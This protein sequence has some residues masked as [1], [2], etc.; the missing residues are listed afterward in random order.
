MS[1]S[2]LGWSCDTLKDGYNAVLT[3]EEASLLE[4]EKEIL[5][6][7]E[8]IGLIPEIP[9]QTVS[10]RKTLYLPCVFPGWI[11]RPTFRR[12]WKNVQLPTPVLTRLPPAEESDSWPPSC[13]PW[14]CCLAQANSETQP[15]ILETHTLALT[16]VTKL[17][18]A[19]SWLLAYIHV[20]WINQHGKLQSQSWFMLSKDSQ[21][22]EPEPVHAD[23]A[24]P[25]DGA[26]DQDEDREAHRLGCM[27][28]PSKSHSQVLKMYNLVGRRCCMIQSHLPQLPPLGL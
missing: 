24:E 25:E 16:V 10:K 19:F 7:I 11:L 28:T 8:D 4:Q 1:T 3:E 22:P 17:H 26:S 23:T 27:H 12:N 18:L 13:S 14:S 5:K 21:P 20:T 2:K 6:E 9:N 15:G